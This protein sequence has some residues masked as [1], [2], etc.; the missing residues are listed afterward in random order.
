LRASHRRSSRSSALPPDPAP[1]C[2]AGSGP[3]RR[4]EAVGPHPEDNKC[5]R[6]TR[7]R[8]QHCQCPAL[9]C[10]SSSKWSTTRPVAF[11]EC[12]GPSRDRP[13]SAIVASP[14]SPECVGDAGVLSWAV[15]SAGRQDKRYGDQ[16]SGNSPQRTGAL[17]SSSGHLFL[18]LDWGVLGVNAQ[19]RLDENLERDVKDLS[20]SK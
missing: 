17:D 12:G 9:C 1:A 5:W 16:W 6:H 15:T 18:R 3:Q 11:R 10:V 20:S 8:R 19:A 14:F 13:P 4:R 2:W 7:S